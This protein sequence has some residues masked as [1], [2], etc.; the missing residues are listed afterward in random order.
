MGIEPDEA[1]LF[2]GFVKGSW[3][4]VLRETFRHKEVIDYDRLKQ[5]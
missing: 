2:I 5:R 3:K 1:R 4:E